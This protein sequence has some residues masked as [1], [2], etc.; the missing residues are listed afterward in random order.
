MRLLSCPSRGN[1]IESGFVEI[2]LV[3]GNGDE[4]LVVRM[5]FDIK[6]KEQWKLNGVQTTKSVV[7]EKVRSLNIQVDNPLQF[8]P[9]DKVGQFSNLSPTELLKHTE[10]A[11]GPKTY[12]IHQEL[13]AA[14]KAVGQVNALH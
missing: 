6:D 14:D 8:L 7:K 5:D 2:E 11:I 1:L 3:D 9:Q 4:N 10:M 13:I 12:A